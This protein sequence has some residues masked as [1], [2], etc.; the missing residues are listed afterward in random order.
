MDYQVQA[1]ADEWVVG[2]HCDVCDERV[3]SGDPVLVDEE[4][5][6]VR[7]AECHPEPVVP[8]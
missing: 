4:Y 6:Y 5:G 7:H 2:S 8:A 1:A 3:E